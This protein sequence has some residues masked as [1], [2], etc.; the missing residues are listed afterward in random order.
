MGHHFVKQEVKGRSGLNGTHAM[1]PPGQLYTSVPNFS[2]GDDPVSE[3]IRAN[4]TNKQ[5]MA[6]IVI[7]IYIPT[8]THSSYIDDRNFK[9]ISN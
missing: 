4:Q 9:H 6:Y 7:K 2:P 5:K 8:Y 1:L 3:P